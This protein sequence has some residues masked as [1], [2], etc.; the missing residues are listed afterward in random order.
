[1]MKTKLYIGLVGSLAA[2]KGVV[3]DYF[4]KK[5]GFVSFSLSFIVH[6]ELKKQGITSFT[7]K[8]LQDIGDDLRAKGG[9]GALA[10][11]AVS[12]LEKKGSIRVIIE[13]IRNPGEVAFL[14]KQPNFVLLAVD[15]TRA[16]R[17]RRVLKRGKP[18]DPKDWKS[19]LKVDKR[20]HGD[21]GNAKGQR[22]RE[23]M[24]QADYFLENN[25]D[26]DHLYK[27]IREVVADIA[28]KNPAYK[29]VLT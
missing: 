6:D 27:G 3:A 12:I 14:K 4:I 8:T 11:R 16:I 15:G 7:R 9:E 10:K 13:G 22:V 24:N 25:K 18:W 29:K 28:K 19:F 5:Y 17:F 26:K 20:D 23:C 2:G 21:K 1:M